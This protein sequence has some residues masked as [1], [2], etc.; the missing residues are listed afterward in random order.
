DG[1]HGGVA[2]NRVELAGG[3]AV[4]TGLN[5][6]SVTNSAIR[7][8]VINGFTG[9]QI[10]LFNVTNSTIQGNYLGLNAAGSAIVP[11]SGNGL[12]MCCGASGN[13]IGGTQ[14]LARN[15]VSSV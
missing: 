6:N 4:A 11:G 7:N 15:V 14:V 2:S 1:G 13:Q 3:G 8:L 5:L 10:Q 9:R 12:E